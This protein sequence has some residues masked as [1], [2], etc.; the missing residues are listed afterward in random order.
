MG[1]RGPKKTPTAILKLRN[2]WRA[3]GRPDQEPLPAFKP[4]CPSFL[5]KHAKAFW[6]KNLPVLMDSGLMAE[7]YVP[8][9]VMLCA[10]Y[11]S[12]RD[13]YDAIQKSGGLPFY[14]IPDKVQTVTKKDGTVTETREPGKMVDHPAGRSEEKKWEQF[15]RALSSFGCDPA[16]H[17]SIEIKSGKP[18]EATGK[19]RF[20]GKKFGN[21]RASYGKEDTV[22]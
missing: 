3:D 20:F 7:L 18:K 22:N 1:K 11:G 6:R 16:A 12:W 13:A 19:D 15:C 10:A 2:S 21:D 14:K 5:N 9:L 17:G 4:K 8:K